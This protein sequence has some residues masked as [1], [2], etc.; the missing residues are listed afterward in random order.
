MKDCCENNQDKHKKSILKKGFNYVVYTIIA[1]ILIWAL[2]KQIIDNSS[3][4]KNKVEINKER[5][6]E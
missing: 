2:V 3:A 4:Q 5:I 1:T 6:K